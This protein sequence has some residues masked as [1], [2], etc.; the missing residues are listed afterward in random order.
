MVE[1][2]QD[3]ISR[4]PN[5]HPILWYTSHPAVFCNHCKKTINPKGLVW[6]CRTCECNECETCGMYHFAGKPV[7]TAKQ[8]PNGHSLQVLNNHPLASCNVCYQMVETDKDLLHCNM[9]DWDSCL[10]CTPMTES[11][12]ETEMRCH[13]GHNLE[14]MTYHPLTTCDVCG[15]SQD[16][17]DPLWMCEICDWNKCVDCAQPRR[18]EKPTRNRCPNGHCLCYVKA[19]SIEKCDPCGRKVK[20]KDVWA[21]ETCKWVR[22]A[23]CG[24]DQFLTILI[25]GL[26][27]AARRQNDCKDFYV[28]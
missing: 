26:D 17:Y 3:D 13:A 23:K 9:C 2:Q 16:S 6:H 27:V 24:Q 12:Q 10:K 28:T 18:S 1:S 21:C 8:C 15:E 14:F 22:C 19:D 7:N 4:C 25:I 20:G 11:V 5:N